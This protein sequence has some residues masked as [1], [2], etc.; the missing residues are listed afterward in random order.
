MK[1]SFKKGKKCNVATVMPSVFTCASDDVKVLLRLVHVLEPPDP[2]HLVRLAKHKFP[3]FYL[4]F[5]GLY[6]N[7][8]FTIQFIFL[9]LL[10]ITISYQFLLMF[11]IIQYSSF[12]N[13]YVYCII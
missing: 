8:Y 11:F 10:I 12:T 5:C 7:I 9:K 13:M 4:E 2:P 6:V 3:D 1:K